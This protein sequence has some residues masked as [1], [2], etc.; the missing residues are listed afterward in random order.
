MTKCATPKTTAGKVADL[1]ALASL[2]A[3]AAFT[4]AP[5]RQM[6]VFDAAD[7]LDR[8]A[9]GLERRAR[10]ELAEPAIAVLPSDA[11]VEEVRKARCRQATRRGTEVYLPSWSA[12]AR[13]LPNAFLRSAL[14]S[15]RRS[16]QS[17]NSRVLSSDPTLLVAGKEIAS[18]RNMTLTFSGYELCQFDRLVYATCLDY[19][20]EAP[21]SPEDSP[22]HVRTSFYE[23]A[24]RMRNEYSVKAHRAIRTVYFA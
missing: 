17:D 11:T 3:E 6:T 8:I 15:T 20:R 22:L 9:D 13:A 2:T 23:F 14:F 4:T 21:L 5:D 24:R 16:I 12:M 10:K 1:R 7:R 18:F 19:Y